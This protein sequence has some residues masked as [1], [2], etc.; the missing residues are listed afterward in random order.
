MSTAPTPEPILPEL[1]LPTLR[2]VVTTLGM[3]PATNRAGLL[4]QLADAR[5]RL[6]GSS[7]DSTLTAASG[8]SLGDGTGFVRLDW[9]DQVGQLAPKHARE[10]GLHI[11]E[12]ADAAEHDA[13]LVAVGRDVIELDEQGIGL[14]LQSVRVVRRQ[15]ATA[16]QPMTPE[17]LAQQ[18]HETYER[19]AP[20]FGYETRRD[21]AVPWQDVPEQNRSL[22][23]AV[24]AELVGRLP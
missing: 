6:Q 12:S 3:N 1:D 4:A 14:L 20:E 21:S 18:F 19:L 5:R 7:S 13:A 24:C 9:G 17:Q 11:I 15:N 23:T 2:G 22:M 16:V 10:L 8:V